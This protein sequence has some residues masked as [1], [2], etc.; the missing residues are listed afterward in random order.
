MGNKKI[1]LIIIAIIAIAAGS[2]FYLK[3]A[4]DTNKQL[5]LHGNID[6]RQFNVSFQVPGQVTKMFFEEGD[7]VQ[8]GDLVAELDDVDYKLQEA[9]AESQVAQANATMVQAKSAYDKYS[10]LYQQDAIPKLTFESYENSFIEA[11]AAYN[12]TVRA[13]D[14]QT[15]QSEYSK[16]YALES[17]IVTARLTEP[18]TVVAKGTA[19]YTLS[20]STPIWVRAYVNEKSL[21]L[22]YEGMP[23]KIMTD[24]IDPT[25]GAKKSYEGRIGYISPE[26]EFT[27]KTVQTTDLRTDLVY[28]IRVYVDQPDKFLRQGMPVTMTIDLQHSQGN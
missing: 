17:G 9:Q 14:L 12:A 1:V 4:P 18:G 11:Q 28:M 15:R 22:I 20:K 2:W 25:T 19:I 13:K 5:I 26:S 6:I 8:K 16:L 24:S 10:V 3:P 23:A 7:T 21:G 27:P